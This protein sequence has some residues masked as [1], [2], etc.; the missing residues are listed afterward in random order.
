MVRVGDGLR[1]GGWAHVDPAVGRNLRLAWMG[2]AIG[3]CLG[4]QAGCA[5]IP[6]PSFAPAAHLRE[7]SMTIS[8]HGHP[9][10]LHLAVPQGGIA[11]P[12]LVLFASGDGGW[13]GRAVDMFHLIGQAGYPVVGIS[14]RAFL[15]LEQT[16][17]ALDVAHLVADYGVMVDGACRALRLAP[18]TPV[19]LSGWSRGAAF[20]VLVASDPEAGHPLAGVIAI[21]LG[22][23]E[24]LQLD[25]DDDDEGGG[26]TGRPGRLLL[27]YERM[28]ALGSLPCAVIQ[29]THDG[30]LPAA[31]ARELFGS[32]G[33][34]R[35][36]YAVEASNHRFSGGLPAMAAALADALRWIAARPSVGVAGDTRGPSGRW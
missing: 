22:P 2:P 7:S 21:G 33:D 3:I 28:A 9:L 30:Y 14:S 11:A 1:H 23:G 26:S 5:G 20:A 13:F 6:S 29:A 32:E 8:L 12:A 36:F 24:D 35:R 34:D 19:I 27:P 4:L 18:S 31:R 15:R 25:A 17:G 10:D 16:R